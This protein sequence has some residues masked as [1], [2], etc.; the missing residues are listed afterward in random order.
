MGGDERQRSVVRRGF[1]KEV[2]LL[3]AL[4]LGGNLLGFFTL[5]YLARILGPEEYGRVA[6]A[7][8]LTAYF[9]LLV[10]YSFDFSAQ[11]RAA[12]LN[13]PQ[14]LAQLMA[15]ILGGRLF[16][17]GVSILILGLLS[18]LSSVQKTWDLVL[19]F[20]GIV[21]AQ[22]FHSGWLLAAKGWV[23]LPQVLEFLQ[24]VVVILGLLLFTR[25]GENGKVYA[26]LMGSSALLSSGVSFFLATRFLGLVPVY[27]RTRG[28]F[29]AL[30]EGWWL[31]LSQGG[32]TLLVGGNPFLLGLFAPSEAVAQYAV[33][34]KLVLTISALFQPLFR[35]L[36]PRFAVR[37]QEERPSLLALGR[38]AFFLFGGLGLGLALGLFF[39]ATWAVEI[40][41]GP[42]FAEAALLVKGLT[43][44]ILASALNT[45][46][47]ML[48][49]VPLG[50]DR[51]FTLALLGAGAL[52]WGLVFLLAPKCAG[53]GVAGA[54]GGAGLF[55]V[56]VQA[57]FL[58][59]REGFSPFAHPNRHGDLDS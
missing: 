12:N 3:Y 41:F 57:L 31:F 28:T 9:L 13:S 53:M 33:A 36:Y 15:E 38:K 29:T 22:I 20:F 30:R 21:L 58:Y 34:E 46:L 16:L 40:V 52:H 37:A 49:L 35:S 5:A 19:P 8:G 27:P 55:L 59:L 25:E 50:H 11:R 6:F 48:L 23:V 32:G 51:P 1:L 26:L 39:S 10:G 56:L 24:R 45:A 4:H 43:P 54:L 17:V 18:P 42:G 14:E 44:W 47:G 2:G 7:Q